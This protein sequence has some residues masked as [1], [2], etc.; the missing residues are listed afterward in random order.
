MTKEE[1]FLT[2]VRQLGPKYREEVIAHTNRL[3]Q[4]K[5][6]RDAEGETADFVK[7]CGQTLNA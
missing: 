5:E 3:A 4:A 1:E 6:A 7:N 2:N